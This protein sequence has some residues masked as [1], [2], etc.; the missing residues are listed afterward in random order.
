MNTII[1][2]MSLNGVCSY[3]PTST[4]PS[5]LPCVCCEVQSWEV[6]LLYEK[7]MWGDWASMTL[8]LALL[9]DYQP[10]AASVTSVGPFTMETPHH[11]PPTAAH[12]RAT[13]AS[14]GPGSAHLSLATLEFT[15]ALIKADPGSGSTDCGNW[16]CASVPGGVIVVS[17]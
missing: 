15:V 11:S 2:I 16:V 10:F 8:P 9:L 17:V 12:Y 6:E 7:I 1:Y 3:S 4:V 13:A 14:A 5:I